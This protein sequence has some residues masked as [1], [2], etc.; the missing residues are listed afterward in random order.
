MTVTYFFYFSKE[1][2][3]AVALP[4]SYPILA[5]YKSLPC[6][7]QITKMHKTKTIERT[8]SPLYGDIHYIAISAIT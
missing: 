8:G 3:N 4:W 6:K 7:Y 5:I 2:K 1:K